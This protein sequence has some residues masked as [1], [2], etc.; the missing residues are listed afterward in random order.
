MRGL[1]CLLFL[2]FAVSIPSFAQEKGVEGHVS[3]QG[4]GIPV[5]KAIITICNQK[6]NILYS[7][8]TAKDG[9]FHVLT[10]GEDLSRFTLKVSCMGYKSVTRIIGKENSFLVELAPNAFVLKDVYVKAEKISHHNDTTSYLVSGFSSAKDRTIGD[11]LKKMPGIEVAKNGSVSYNGKAINEFWVEGVDL[12]D[13]QYNIATRN[14]SHDLISKVDIIENHQSAKVLKDSKSE[15]GT[16]LNLNLKDKAKGRWSGNAK[17]GGGMPKLW[18][19]ELFAARLSGTNQ[20]AITMKTNNSGKDIMS[21]NNILTLDELLS[22]DAADEPNTILDVSQE[23]PGNLDD[24]YTRNARTHVINVSNVQKISGT[25]ILHSKIYY[26]DDRNICDSEKGM[27]YFLSD[28][29]LTEN[30]QEHSILGT[31]EL[32]ASVLFKSDKKNGFFSDEL[33]YSSLWKR[34]R[35]KIS[36]DYSRASA[37]HSDIHC[38]ENKLKWILPI[39]K[40]YLSIESRNKYQTMPE[41]SCVEAE[42]QSLQ[43]VKRGNFISASKLNYTWNLKRWALSLYAES[44]VSI[45]D[46]KSNFMSDYIDTTYFEN[47]YANYHTLTVRPSLTYKFKSIFSEIQIPVSIYHYWGRGTSEKIFCLPKWTLSW[48]ANSYW[49]FRTSLS[50]GSTAPSVNNSYEAPVMTDYKTFRSSPFISYGQNKQNLAFAVN[51]TDYAHM[52]FGNISFVF[53][54]GNDKTRIIKH[55]ERDLI[56]YSKTEWDNSSSGTMMLGNVSKRFDTI[57]GTISAKCLYFLNETTIW[58]NGVSVQFNTNMLQTSVGINSNMCDWLEIDYQLGYNLNSLCFSAAK[59]STKL[60]TQQLHVSVSPIEA[61]TLT[62]AAEHYA[63]FFS[64][65]PSKQTIFNDIKCSYRYHKIDIVGRLTNIFNQKYYCQTTYSDLS[66]SY[67]KYALRGRN[68]LL[69]LVAYF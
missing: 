40:H 31:K 43:N 6:N 68:I 57:K 15:G 13:G 30:T 58:Q 24:K 4:T 16:I 61:L 53:N 63:S 25:A 67:L 33:K 10:K 52:L 49:K 35:T 59:T 44:T 42:G 45:S 26:T 65:L 41:K 19:E 66:S 29:T 55:V 56:Y 69:S 47:S 54:R 38:L 39:G 1:Y 22:Q 12:F 23:K 11:V 5:N 50:L 37:I 17:L 48:Q 28:S 51:Y 21:E 64:A 46:F 7:G 14:I 27:S 32:A 9:K 18:E 20:T 3:E 60:L 8:I 2:V 62:I 36:G 34:N